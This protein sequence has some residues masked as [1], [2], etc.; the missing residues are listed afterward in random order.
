MRGFFEDL[1]SKAAILV[2]IALVASVVLGGSLTKSIV[3]ANA[4]G[5]ESI[6]YEVFKTWMGNITDFSFLA[7]M[8][9]DFGLFLQITFWIFVIVFGIYVVV[10]IQ[11]AGKSEYEG[12]E[13]GSSH[14]STGGEEYRKRSDGKEILNRKEGFILSRNHYLGT[15]LK[16]VIINKNVLVVG[17]SGSGKTACYIKPNILQCLGSYVITD[18]K[19]ELYKETSKFLQSEGYDIKVFNLVNP[20][21]SDFYNPLFNICSEQDVDTLAHILVTGVKKKVAEMIRSGKTLLKC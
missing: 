15:D 21:F 8:F 19:G 13:N 16:K 5:A 14:W 6:I 3:D 2:I 17:G 20:K 9:S 18:P 12:R 4:S 11:N 1:K 10:K 7:G